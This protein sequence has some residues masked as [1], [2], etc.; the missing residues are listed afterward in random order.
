[1]DGS[2]VRKIEKMRRLTVPELRQAYAEICGEP[3]KSSH[4]QYLFRRIAWQIQAQA[5]GGLSEIALRRAA[6]IAD[7]AD[8]RSGI[9]QGFWTWPQPSRDTVRPK[10]TMGRDQRLPAPGTILRRRYRSQDI[11]VRVLDRGFE[12]QARQYASLSAVARA[13][14][15]TNWNGLLFFGL[16]GRHDG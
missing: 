4:K 1:M 5:E 14:T 15:G 12:Y 2:V 8:I 13:V 16:T 6:E 3:A 11:E 9:P 10:P 7:D